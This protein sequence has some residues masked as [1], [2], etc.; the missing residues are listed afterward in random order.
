M[1]TH[2]RV[3]ATLASLIPALLIVASNLL[4]QTLEGA[5][6]PKEIRALVDAAP[7]A[8]PELAADILIRVAQSGKVSDR[9]WKLELLEQAFNVAAGA[10]YGVALVAA[11]GPARNIDSDAGVRDSALQARIDT[12]SLRCRAVSAT[13][14]I[15]HQ[16]A[17]ELLREIPPMAPPMHACTDAVTESPDILFET[18]REI[19]PLAFGRGER[20]KGKQ[21]DLAEGYL[22]VLSSPAQL[23]PALMLAG[24]QGIRPYELARL[25]GAIVN[26]IQSMNSDDRTFSAAVNRKLMEDLAG[27]AAQCQ[28]RQYSPGALV[29]AVRAYLARHLSAA[30]CG[31]VTRIEN[32]QRPS[33]AESFNRMLLPLAG[34]GVVAPL[35]PDETKPAA[36]GEAA[37]VYEFYSKPTARKLMTD[38]KRLRFGTEE[39]QS[40]NN[41]RGPRQDGMA[42]FLTEE[43]RSAPEWQAAAQEFLTE[44]EEWKND[45]DEPPAAYFH[46]VC[47]IYMG[48]LDIAPPGALREQVLSS[49]IIFLKNSE[50]ERNSP[51]EWWWE[52]SHL[53]KGTVDASP[54]EAG[55]IREEI[56]AKGDPVMILLVDAD[57]LVGPAEF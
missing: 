46:E 13:L 1:S 25:A 16:R 41:L 24:A 38:Y 7:V 20:S 9:A 48:L 52:L 40:A 23:A 47:G 32:G 56:R 51:P 39:Q 18:L 19:L 3:H 6:R 45:N 36:V 27:F 33:L 49:Y 28:R 55:R 5:D 43:Q 11:V 31:D 44:V 37:R 8:P 35:T 53:M 15:D 10:K 57:K 26:S 42:Q 4:T 14:R 34:E 22:R 50:V 54:R 29:A 12:L 17:L 21:I 30:G 2:T